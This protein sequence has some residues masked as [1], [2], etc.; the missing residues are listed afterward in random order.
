MSTPKILAL[1]PGIDIDA[2]V[3]PLRNVAEQLRTIAKEI[4]EGVFGVVDRA[5]LVLNTESGALEVFAPGD[6]NVARAYMDLQ[7]GAM[8]ILVMDDPSRRG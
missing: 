1:R 8:Q 4:D 5:A 7:A 2:E 6:T 3:P